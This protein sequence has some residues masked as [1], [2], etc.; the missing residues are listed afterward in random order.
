M[1]RTRT[2]FVSLP[3]IINPPIRT[4]SPVSTAVRVEIL[5]S[6]LVGGVA[7]GVGVGV[8]EPL[9]VGVGE[10]LGVGVGEPFGVGVG[11]PEG[12]GVGV[13]V[14]MTPVPA[15]KERTPPELNAKCPI[16]SPGSPI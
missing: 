3:V 11:E 15:V 5:P 7:L 8:G 4:L 9:G 16:R 14:G 13:G 2:V 12:V 6:V 10:P 1:A